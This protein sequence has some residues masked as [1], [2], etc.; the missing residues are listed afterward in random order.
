M[1]RYQWGIGYALLPSAIS[2]PFMGRVSI[3]SLLVA[4]LNK[5]ILNQLGPNLEHFANFGVF[6]QV[7]VIDE[8][9]G[10]LSLVAAEQLPTEGHRCQLDLFLRGYSL[11]VDAKEHTVSFLQSDVVVEGSEKRQKLSSLVSDG[12]V[13]F[14]DWL[15]TTSPFLNSFFTTLVSCIL[16]GLGNLYQVFSIS[17]MFFAGG[18]DMSPIPRQAYHTDYDPS[19]IMHVFDTHCLMWPILAIISFSNFYKMYVFAKTHLA[20]PETESEFLDVLEANF[21]EQVV[22][23]CPF[24]SIMLFQSNCIHAGMDRPANCEDQRI[25]RLHMYLE[26]TRSRSLSALEIEKGKQGS[27]AFLTTHILEMM[28]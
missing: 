1:P 15:V 4:E 13:T 20:T 27:S 8:G 17:L 18:D 23:G 24:G 12:S 5:I 3:Q 11:V 28:K 21:G 6:N 19:V 26:P 16:N 2:F 10:S 22:I 14:P 9:G 7:T 25:F